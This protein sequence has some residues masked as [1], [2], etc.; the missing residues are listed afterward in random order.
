MRV[1]YVYDKH[2]SIIIIIQ[3]NR[4][5]IG[6]GRG[7]RTRKISFLSGRHRRGDDRQKQWNVRHRDQKVLGGRAADVQQRHQQQ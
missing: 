5:Y 7:L 2:V 6:Q 1:Y 3:T 4:F